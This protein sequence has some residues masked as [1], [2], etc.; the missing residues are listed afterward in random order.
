M[1]K[2]FFNDQ[3]GIKFL[4]EGKIMLLIWKKIKKKIN[5]ANFWSMGKG[6]QKLTTGLC[7][8]VF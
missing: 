8:Y 1:Y 6:A 2:P 4:F 3:G 5:L 7:F